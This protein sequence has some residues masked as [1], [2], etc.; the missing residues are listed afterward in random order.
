MAVDWERST[1]SALFLSD[2][3]LPQ[4][5]FFLCSP[6]LTFLYCLPRVLTAFPSLS[7]QCSPPPPSPQAD[8][9]QWRREEVSW[10]LLPAI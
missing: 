5:K 7:K 10:P 3:P 4:K 6:I 8:L 9:V 1:P 2:A